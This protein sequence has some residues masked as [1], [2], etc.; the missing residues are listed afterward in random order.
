MQTA[1]P[2]RRKAFTLLEVVVAMALFAVT[3]GVLAQAAN[4][5]LRATLIADAR[6]SR[7]QDR[8]FLRENILAIEDQAT[9]ETGGEIETPESGS[10]T[11]SAY[12]Y[13]T[14]AADL[15][16]VTLVFEFPAGETLPAET[17]TETLYAY[18]PAW[19]DAA[20]RAEFISDFTD[21][22]NLYRPERKEDVAEGEGSL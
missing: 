22:L 16:F 1:R 8:F 2:S 6:V 5:A 20:Q 14:T 21:Y 17:L 18:R 4:N 10:V 7:E 3:V 9:L 13:P 11:W 12:V 15:F 19:S